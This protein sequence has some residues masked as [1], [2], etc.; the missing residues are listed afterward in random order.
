[1]LLLYWIERKGVMTHTQL[2]F[3]LCSAILSLLKGS[4]IPQWFRRHHV[5]VT[6]S[7]ERWECGKHKKG[8]KKGDEICATF[9]PRVEIERQRWGWVS[10]MRRAMIFTEIFIRCS[11]RQTYSSWMRVLCSFNNIFTYRWISEVYVIGS[12]VDI[13]HG[14]FCGCGSTDSKGEVSIGESYPR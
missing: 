14:S 1:M 13:R 6:P 9:P 11:N 10:R 2:G 3:Y 12:A 8:S 7:K 4:T 5:S